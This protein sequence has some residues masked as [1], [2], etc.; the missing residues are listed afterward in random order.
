MSHSQSNFK[1]VT[2][3]SCAI[4]S[5]SRVSQPSVMSQPSGTAAPP[6]DLL[7]D[8]SANHPTPSVPAPRLH[9]YISAHLHSG[10][11]T[12]RNHVLSFILACGDREW[13]ELD[14]IPPVC[15][16]GSVPARCNAT[17]PSRH[18]RLDFQ[19]IRFFLGDSLGCIDIESTSIR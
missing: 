19:Q 10:A 14:A 4:F 15:S 18:S 6:V 8:R 17:L 2:D 16:G 13:L 1:P 9:Q 12:Y 5:A 11:G 7:D 3:T